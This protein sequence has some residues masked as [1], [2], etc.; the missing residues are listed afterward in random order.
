[1]DAAQPLSEFLRAACRD[2]LERALALLSDPAGDRDGAVHESR[3]AVRRVRAWLRLGDRHRRTALAQVDIRLRAL[4]RTLGPLRDGAS[5]IEALERLRRRREL[6]GQR[7][8]LAAARS[9]MQ[10]LLERRWACRPRHGKVWQGLL[11]GLTEL[12]ASLPEWPLAGWSEVEARSAL[13]RS[14]RRACAG[15][16]DCSA[17]IGAARRHAWRG[18]VR[19][20]WLQTQLLERRGLASEGAALKRLVQSLG[21]EHD[22][23]LVARALAGLGLADAPTRKLRMLVQAQRRALATRNDARA[24]N[25]LRRELAPPEIVRGK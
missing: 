22:L 19:I 13:R 14:F 8:P 15:R 18:R 24:R 1:M 4:R 17:R 20:L 9:R 5:R 7:L 2:E 6:R 3:K 21:N 25:L 10:Q 11:R 12:V 16:E 23:A